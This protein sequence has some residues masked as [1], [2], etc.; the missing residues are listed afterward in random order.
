M[1]AAISCGV[2]GA[3]LACGPEFGEVV[4]IVLVP[5]LGS[6]SQREE[7]LDGELHGLE[8]ADVDD[9]DAVGS[10]VEGEVHLLPDFGDGVGVEPFV[11]A[12]AADV[13]EVIV[14]AG[15]AG[16]FALFRR[17]ETAEVAP[18]VVAPEEGDVVGDA[19]AFFVVALDFLVEA[20]T[21]GTLVMS[22]LTVSLRI[23]RWS[24]TMFSSVELPAGGHG[25]VIEA[26]HAESDDLLVVL[27]ALHAGAP[28]VVDACAF[29][30]VVPWAVVAGFHSFS[31]RIMG[32]SCEVPMTMPYSSASFGVQG[33]VC[34]EGV[35]PHGGPEEVGLEAE[36]EFEDLGVELVVEAAE[37][38][39]RS[40]R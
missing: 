1:R 37:I 31:A 13:V 3:E 8:V 26:A 25:R 22:G 39:R 23:S 18:V 16:A 2:F 29:L 35:V 6:A 9:P 5:S 12:W 19:H 21:C 15:A 10:V 20:Q 27:V 32:S 17:G 38:F 4:E 14:D 36:Q 28:E 30:V 34:V 40:S 33:I 7:E 24:A 11:V